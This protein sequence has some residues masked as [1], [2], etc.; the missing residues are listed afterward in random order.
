MQRNSLKEELREG[1]AAKARV[2]VV[3]RNVK[4]VEQNSPFFGIFQPD[5][6]SGFV[7]F[8]ICHSLPVVAGPAYHTGNYT[9]WHPAALAKSHRGLLFKQTNLHHFIKSYGDDDVTRDRIVGAVVMTS[10]PDEPDGGWKIPFTK[11]EAIPIRA[12]AT[13]F[14]QAEGALEMLNDH[15]SGRQNWSVS[16][17]MCGRGVDEMAVYFP[18]K[19]ELI[20]FLEVEDE[21]LAAA[22]KRDDCNCLCLGKYQGEQ[23]ALCYGGE[24]GEVIFRGVGF[25]PRPAEKEAKITGVTLSQFNP[26][27]SQYEVEE[28]PKGIMAMVASSA[29]EASITAAIEACYRDARLVKVWTEG[30]ASLKDHPWRLN[31]SAE[32]PVAEIRLG[33]SRDRGK[34]IL[35]HLSE[36]MAMIPQTAPI[37]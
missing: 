27:R 37:K 28:K 6:Y 26:M 14:K 3:A 33:Q 17:E 15:K 22:V 30:Q 35:K 8:D 21:I 25:T 4:L 34:H 10:Y 16:I 23:L 12:C 5:E 18:N 32:N 20:P 2:D 31:A 24:L 1:V 36:L 9:C 7:E 11:E 19:R 29:K 13:I